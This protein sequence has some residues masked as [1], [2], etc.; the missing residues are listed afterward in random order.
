MQIRQ[1]FATLL[2]KFK[3]MLVPCLLFLERG[4][5]SDSFIHLY[6]I[7]QKFCV[8]CAPFPEI[9]EVT[10]VEIVRF[11]K[12]Q[13]IRLLRPDEGLLLVRGEVLREGRRQRR[14]P[15]RAADLRGLRC[16]PL[17]VFSKL[18]KL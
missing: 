9:S 2:R 11:Q 1:N 3:N 17:H 8:S 14:L 16:G 12:R 18:A 15:L 13:F 7:L 10:V 5:R 4:E 6:R